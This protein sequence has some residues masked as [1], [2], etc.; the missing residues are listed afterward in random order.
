MSNK[1][2]IFFDESFDGIAKGGIF[3]RNDLFKFFK[4]LNE[5]NIRPVGIIVTEDYNME[6]LINAATNEGDKEDE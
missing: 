4:K 3:V 6:I 2:T 1:G 5:S